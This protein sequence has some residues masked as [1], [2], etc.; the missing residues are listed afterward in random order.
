MNKKLV[1]FS[2]VLLAGLSLLTTCNFG[3]NK[4]GN[5]WN[6]GYGYNNIT[7]SGTLNVTCGGK[8]VPFVRIEINS[9]QGYLVSSVELNSPS[10]NT[11]WSNTIMELNTATQICYKVRGYA[12]YNG[13]N[14][15]LFVKDITPNPPIS[16]YK[17]NVSGLNIDIGDMPN[18]FDSLKAQNAPS[19]I[20]N[21]WVS[22]E[23]TESY[24]EGWHK[25]NVTSGTTYYF[26][27]NRSGDNTLQYVDMY[28]YDGAGNLITF[29]E[30]GAGGKISF[31]ANSNIVY[32]KVIAN[33]NYYEYSKD[34][35]TYSIYYSTNSAIK[36]T[37]KFDGNGGAG[38]FKKSETADEGYLIILPNSSE[39]IRD[40]YTF[41]GWNTK[42]DGTGE[43]YN[44]T[45]YT[46]ERDIT[47]YAN[48][49]RYIAGAY[50]T[51]ITLNLGVW[52]NGEI[53]N[54]TPDKALWYTFDVS[55]GRTY[56]IWMNDSVSGDGTKTLYV[57]FAASYGN[58]TSIFDNA[59]NAYGQSK[60]FTAVRTDKVRI[61]VVPR[62]SGYTGTFAI[63]YTTNTSRP[64]ASGTESNPIFLKPNEWYNGEINQNTPNGEMW[65]YFYYQYT[66]QNYYVWWNDKMPGGGDGTKTLDVKVD[67]F[68]N[69]GAIA[70]K[71]ASDK[72]FVDNAWEAPKTIFSNL[73]SD[74][75]V[76]IR[77]YPDD[78]YSSSVKETG[79][80]GIVYS[81]G[82]TRP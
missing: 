77:V 24:G 76:K 45:L 61:K 40:G 11:Q 15:L 70:F 25:I 58:G 29:N 9:T 8:T 6:D 42:A 59:I 69:G 17:S 57:T 81:T 4:D 10:G 21:R 48:W 75:M 73:A 46:V 30:Y 79:T 67:G 12:Y 36:Y 51:P 49:K 7:L 44:S 80:F 82:K 33:A 66:G 5:D 43:N 54:S 60:Q 68:F 47:L 65:F 56:Y 52:D 13:M 3:S 74:N 26:W 38:T 32:I 34:T 78:S 20:A 63:A 71:D 41:G 55:S 62:T 1:V 2:A 14:Q 37:V 39:V 18:G 53:N 27:L 16:V 31:T 50:E 28:A 23:I 72:T 35:G 19:L 64:G 22:G